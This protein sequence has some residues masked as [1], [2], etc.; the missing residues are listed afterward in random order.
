[1]T[2]SEIV[3][4]IETMAVASNLTVRGAAS[5]LSSSTYISLERGDRRYFDDVLGKSARRAFSAATGFDFPR[6]PAPFKIR[7]A[8][9]AAVDGSATHGA[10]H[11]TVRFDRDVTDVLAK[12][13][14]AIRM[15]AV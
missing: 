15:L 10:N 12:I 8:D 5:S 7:I 4:S 9:H 11:A 13:D 1:M 6:A 2:M 3:A 14:V